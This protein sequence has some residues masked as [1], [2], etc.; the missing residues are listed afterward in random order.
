MHRLAPWAAALVFALAAVPATFAKPS[1]PPGVASSA[2]L[3]AGIDALIHAPRFANASWGIEVVSLDTG[4]TLYAHDA[5]RLLE[6]ASTAKLFTAALTLDRLGADQRT[7][8]RLLARGPIRHGR[9]DGTLVLYGMGDPTLGTAASADWADRLATQLLAHGVRRVHGDLVGDDTY[10]AGPPIGSGWE[11][12]DLLGAF[13][14]PAAAL[15]VDENS[16]WLTLTPAAQAGRTVDLALDPPLAIPA[17]DSRLITAPAN[18]A[19]DLNLYRAPGSDTLYAFGSLPAASAPRRLRLA[20]N[21][22]A[23]VAAAQLRD[24]LIRH[25]VTI[26][27]QVRTLHWPQDDTAVTAGA[28]LVGEIASPPLGEILR[29]GLKRSQN[30]YLQNLLLMS[31]VQ[32]RTLAEQSDAP[33]LGFITTE[34]WGL[35]A[36]RELLDRIGIAPADA[37]LEEGSGLSRQNLVTASAMVRLLQY[38]AAQPYAASLR[39]MLPLAG[40]DG[41]LIGRMRG[42]PAAGNVQAKTGSMTYV[43]ALAGYVTTASGQHLAFA[44]LLNSYEPAA[45]DPPASRELDAIAERLAA[46]RHA[47]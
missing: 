14:A 34:A 16:G 22:P 43:H 13:A 18:S 19:G 40:V 45:G 32:A 11:V 9:L 17:I 12:G 5:E 31:G 29:N 41:S 23:R 1:A 37:R 33:P 10:F 7:A 2:P 6:P 25:G 39:D 8:T 4:R 3:A 24:A 28:T 21:D 15:S 47:P 35:R 26:D 20:M 30:L 44:L 46:D 36:L 42:T 38:L 27:G